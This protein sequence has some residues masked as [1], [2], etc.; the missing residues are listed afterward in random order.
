MVKMKRDRFKEIL[1]FFQPSLIIKIKARAYPCV[2]SYSPSTNNIRLARKKLPGPN[3]LAYFTLRK[4]FFF[5]N[6]KVSGENSYGHL[7]C[8]SMAVCSSSPIKVNLV[9]H[10]RFYKVFCNLIYLRSSQVSRDRIH[11]TSFSS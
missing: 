8:L 1:V 2:T 6:Q 11:N 10:G 3:T 5:I 9:N 4:K 7:N